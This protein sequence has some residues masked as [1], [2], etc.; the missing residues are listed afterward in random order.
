MFD[1]SQ[2]QT[3]EHTTRY[4]VVVCRKDNVLADGNNLFAEKW[5]NVLKILISETRRDFSKHCA[6]FFRAC[7][8]NYLMI[9][10]QKLK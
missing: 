9:T 6:A 2:N 10:L 4:R 8:L 7:P 5:R 3:G 1:D